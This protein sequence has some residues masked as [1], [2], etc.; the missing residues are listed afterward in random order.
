MDRTVEN[1]HDP[2]IRDTP[3]RPPGLLMSGYF[4]EHFG[5]HTV[6]RFGTNDW[7]LTYTLR[8]AG[9]YQQPGGVSLLARPGDLVL[10][11]PGAYHDYRCPPKQIWQFVWAHF[12]ARPSW[13]GLMK[14]PE[15][16]KGLFQLSIRDAKARRRIRSAFFRCHF[17]AQAG[18]GGINDDLALN[19]MEEVLLTAA[20]DSAANSKEQPLSPVIRRVVE[21][22]GTDVAQRHSVPSLASFAR[23]SP[24]RL[25]HRFKEETGDSIISYLLKLRLRQAARQLEFSG[26]RVKE[27]AA[28]V[29]FE[30][31][32]YF[33]RQ[34]RKHYG[35][36]PRQYLQKVTD[37]GRFAGVGDRG[38]SK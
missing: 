17:D 6:R 15:I 11:E 14:W 7:V 23:L 28:D 13:I 16:G 29:G 18:A 31:E 22:L 24:S 3:S 32:F 38:K 2:A 36:S 8:G 20:R 37:G 25:S 35:M 1:M 10:L 33:S 19:G 34:F 27:I 26:R 9:L 30:S 12:Y 4:R 21:L 5:Y